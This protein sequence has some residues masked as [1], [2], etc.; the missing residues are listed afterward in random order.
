MKFL[1]V[2]LVGLL[3]FSQTSCSQSQVTITLDLILTAADT[4]V[5][6]LQSTGTIPAAEA[7]VIQQYLSEVNDAVSYTTTELASS[8]STTVKTAKIT[9]KFASIVV[10]QLSGTPA[11][12][13]TTI[14]AVVN[15]VS[16]FLSTLTTTN[17][18]LIQFENSFTG[19]HSWKLTRGDKQH[20]NAIAAKAKVLKAKL[21][22][23]PKK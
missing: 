19:T 21:N 22:A 10:P 16:N 2:G 23:L 8:D 18:Q 9:S 6:T 4:A 5:S 11:S 3:L 15:A 1:T 20:L 14:S 13:V 17:A 7:A 12:I